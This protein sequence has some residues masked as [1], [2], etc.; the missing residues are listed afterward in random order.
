MSG[1]GEAGAALLGRPLRR[2]AG[3]AG[4]DLSQLVRID[5]A[6]GDSAIVKSGP[7]P[8]SEA[9]MLRALAGAGVPAPAVLAVDDRLLVLEALPF[10]Q[11]P[12]A[13]WDDLG[14]VVRRLHETRGEG[15]GWPEDYAFA[16][17]AIPNAPLAD[18][19]DFWAERRLLVHLPQLPAPLARRIE[20]LCAGLGERLPRRPPAALLHGDLWSG[21]VL[22]AGG[23]VTGLIDP[24][25]YHGHGEVDL[26]MLSLFGSPDS[27]FCDAYGPL[28]PGHEERLPLYQLWPALVH[29]RLFGAGYRGLV[30]GLLGA[31]RA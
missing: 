19:P 13:A 26:A 25:C 16:E 21:N 24:A 10:G 23:R 27:A 12:S 30:E 4:G 6:D 11:P 28:E 8:R 17:V 2:S 15:Y 1:L 29:L 7:A 5:L 18:W 9:A 22:V 20:G 3:V 14:R 31:A